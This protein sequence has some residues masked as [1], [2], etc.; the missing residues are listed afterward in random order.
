MSSEM[1][2][3]LMEEENR[4]QEVYKGSIVKGRVMIEKEDSFYVDLN[5]KTDGILPKDQILE[6]ETVNVGDEITVQVVKIDKNTGDILLSKRKV[7]EFKVWDDIEAGNIV[8][9]RIVETNAK[10]LIGAYKGSVRGFIPLS[11]IELKF[12]GE[13]ALKSYVGKT[14]EVEVIDV[15]PKKRRLIL[16]RKNIL[17]KQQE[18][19]RKEIMDKVVEGAT[20]E[21]TIKDIKDYGAFVD[22]GG[23]TGLVHVSEISWDRS[24][25]IKKLY[26]LEDK[27]Q[28]Q[29]ISFDKETDRLSLSIKSLIEHPWNEF[30]AKNKV[31]DIVSGEVK[32]IKEYGAF[33]NLHPTVDGFVHISN[34]SSEFVK[35]PGEVLKV[36]QQVDVRIISIDE[37]TKKIELSMILEE[38]KAEEEVAPESVQEETIS[39]EEVAPE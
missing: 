4:Y 32:N 18:E 12:I 29:V 19:M 3:L 23:I 15:D 38:P 6:T 34:L 14:F 1:E 28:V 24:D 21:G 8:P 31:S 26:K 25:N 33:I 2:K 9:V 37:E 16:S 7:D 30:I 13:E 39:S 27:V 11:H 35:N 10:G 5:Y 36:G 17:L 20:F 22:I